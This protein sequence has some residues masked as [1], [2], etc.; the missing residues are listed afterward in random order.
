M[1][2]HFSVNPSSFRLRIKACT[3]FRLIAVPFHLIFFDVKLIAPQGIIPI[4][5]IYPSSEITE[6]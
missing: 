4:D 5:P 1:I 2:Q 3:P 6:F